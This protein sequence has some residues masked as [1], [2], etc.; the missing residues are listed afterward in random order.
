M[1]EETGVVI[2]QWLEDLSVGQQLK[3]NG[4]SMAIMENEEYKETKKVFL[5]STKGHISAITSP[6]EPQRAIRNDALFPK[7]DLIQI[8]S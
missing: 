6:L 4:L 2:S 7:A 3:R 8:F 5:S 1:C